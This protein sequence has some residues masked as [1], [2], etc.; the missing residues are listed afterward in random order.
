M[1]E[2]DVQANV[3]TATD[4]L[5]TRLRDPSKPLGEVGAYL[6]A[7][8]KQRFLR[9]Q[10]PDGNPWAGLAPS[11]IADK[12]RR[13]APLSILRDR[14][15]LASS[16]AFNVSGA[17]VRVGTSQEYAIWLQRGTKKMPA[18]PFMGFEPGDAAAISSIFRRH[19][20]G[21]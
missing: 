10:D 4:E 16:I 14:G 11:T 20:Q 5:I 7:K 1:F 21:D 15:L 19:I 3:L 18:R 17:E 12:K 8:A 6:E 2:I 9:E 13:G